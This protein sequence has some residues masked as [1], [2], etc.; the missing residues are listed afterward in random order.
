M[1][2]ND[3]ITFP[4]TFIIIGRRGAGKTGLGYYLLESLSKHYKINPCVMGLPREKVHLLSSKIMP[5]FDLDEMMDDSITFIDE[6]SMLFHAR[7]YRKAINKLMDKII[8]IS[9]QKRQIII[10]ASHHTRKIDVNIITDLDGFVFKE[11]SELHIKFERKEIKNFT[12]E[13]FEF[14]KKV[15]GNK[16]KYSYVYSRNYT[17]EM[18][19]P[20]ASFWSEALSNAFGGI[21]VGTKKDPKTVMLKS[22]A[23]VQGD[24]GLNVEILN[25]INKTVEYANEERRR[26]EILSSLKKY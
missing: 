19:N 20:L 16:K 25:Y 26:F 18:I 17:G 23:A 7:E 9:R 4:S 12:E 10:F 14:F 2:W 1:K 11:P 3:I 5:I 6:A 13:A 24:G 15:Q 21:S 22:K 8:A